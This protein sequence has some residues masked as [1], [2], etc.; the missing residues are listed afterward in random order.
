MGKGKLVRLVAA[1]VLMVLVGSGISVKTGLLLSSLPMYLGAACYIFEKQ[2]KPWVL[3]TL[4]VAGLAVF[5]C[6][7][8][9]PKALS[10]IRGV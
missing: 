4:L 2:P 9:V 7:H 10:G 8:T 6:G 3:W 5:F 1:V